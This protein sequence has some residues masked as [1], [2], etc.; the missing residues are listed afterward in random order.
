MRYTI[1]L[2]VLEELVPLSVTVSPKLGDDPAVLTLGEL[3][4]DPDIIILAL[5]PIEMRRR[6]GSPIAPVGI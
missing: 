5:R 6:Y 4:L 1:T 2:R 3:N